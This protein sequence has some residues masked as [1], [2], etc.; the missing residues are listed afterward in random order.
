[1]RILSRRYRTG[2][3]TTIMAVAPPGGCNV[4]V[5]CIAMIDMDTDSGAESQKPNDH[6]IDSLYTHTPTKAHRP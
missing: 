1:M 4:F 2:R 5:K 6:A 3:P